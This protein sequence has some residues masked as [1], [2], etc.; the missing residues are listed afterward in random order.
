MKKE[1]QEMEFLINT[2]KKAI[3]NGKEE[4]FNSRLTELYL[5][6]QVNKKA[7]DAMKVL[8]EEEK[9]PI[10]IPSLAESEKTLI[11]SVQFKAPVKRPK[12]TKSIVDP[13]GISSRRVSPSC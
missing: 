10:T 7:Y 6:G 11:P 9:E 13:C 5:E 1:V 4:E 3:E 12:K 8:L 2:Y